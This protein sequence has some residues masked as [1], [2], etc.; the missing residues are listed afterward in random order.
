MDKLLLA[1]IAISSNYVGNTLNCDV[2]NIFNKHMY[3]KHIIILYIIFFTIDS[4]EKIEDSI[5]NTFIIWLYYLAL[6]KQKLNSFIIIVIL[7]TMINCIDK[8]KL[9]MKS[10]KSNIILAINI[11]LFYGLVSNYKSPLLGSPDC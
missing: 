8:F 2:Q 6:T 9:E 11:I 7:Y 4:N 3:L 1:L 10:T 5:K